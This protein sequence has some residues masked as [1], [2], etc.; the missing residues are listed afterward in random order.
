MTIEPCL[1]EKDPSKNL[2]KVQ[3]EPTIRKKVRLTKY[4]NDTSF[5]WSLFDNVWKVG[6]LLIQWITI[7]RSRAVISWTESQWFSVNWL[8]KF[9]SGVEKW[10]SDAFRASWVLMS[11]SVNS[12]FPVI[13]RRFKFGI[14]G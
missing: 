5:T 4:D 10:E 12:L 11:F 3:S 7:K 6:K 14:I 9:G 2:P 13:E 1:R 8:A